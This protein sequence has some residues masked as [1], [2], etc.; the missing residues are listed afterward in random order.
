MGR[1]L[2]HDMAKM[3]LTE[4]AYTT[5]RAIRLG[6]I[7][8]VVL[9]SLW[10]FLKISL[11]VWSTIHPAPPPPPTVGFGPL[12]AVPFPTEPNMPKLTFL[13]ETPEGGLPKLTNQMK[14][15]FMPKPGSNFLDLDSAKKQAK[16]LGFV[17]DPI[18][19]SDSEY[20]WKIEG[21]Y[22]FTAD[23]LKRTFVYNYDY[24]T[25]QT[26]LRPQKLPGNEEIAQTAK[27]FLTRIVSIPEDLASGKATF[28]YFRFSGKDLVSV[29]SLS[30]ADFI[31]VSL[32][33]TDYD[34]IPVLPPDPQKGLVWFLASNSQ[35]RLK[36]F[37]HM[38]YQYFPTDNQRFETYPLKPVETAW[39]EI[40]ADKYYLARL[41]EQHSNT[42]TIRRVYLG[43]FDPPTPVGYL[44][45]I[46]VF[47]GDSNFLGYVSAVDQSIIGQ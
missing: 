43:Y 19:L 37:V 21:G 12:P 31:R 46:Y 17:G 35:D 11:K 25:D 13:L 29:L 8:S 6:A 27:G 1:I 3:T 20:Q 4:T 24:T 33:R 39:E 40:K 44:L 26:L 45:P 16:S 47:E 34:S 41:S 7:G 9:F 10:V 38:E 15:Y 5:R 32:F 28:S 14:V 2:I 18:K 42:L 30:D 36:Q 22:T 23:I